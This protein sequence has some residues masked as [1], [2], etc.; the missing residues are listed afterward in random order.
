MNETYQQPGRWHD[1]ILTETANSRINN[2]DA[3]ERIMSHILNG[4]EASSIYEAIVQAKNRYGWSEVRTGGSCSF[5]IDTVTPILF[6]STFSSVVPV[7][8]YFYYLFSVSPAGERHLPVLHPAPL[9]G[10]ASGGR[11]ADAQLHLPQQRQ[12]GQENRSSRTAT[13]CGHQCN[14]SACQQ[15]DV[16]P[17]FLRNNSNSHLV[18]GTSEGGGQEESPLQVTSSSFIKEE[19]QQEEDVVS[20][21]LSSPPVVMPVVCSSLAQCDAIVGGEEERREGDR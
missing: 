15:L 7:P 8:I 5:N 16:V 6:G 1:I 20:G 9:H 10:A 13:S 11:R 17:R 18:F 12:R 4:L 14:G 21:T 3:S 2:V 19:Q